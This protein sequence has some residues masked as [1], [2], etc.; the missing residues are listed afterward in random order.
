MNGRWLIGIDEAGYGPSM[1]PLVLGATSWW[2]PT[3]I[4][5]EE[6]AEL[7]APEIQ[8]KPPFPKEEHI[9]IGDSK[10]IMKGSYG[11][12]NLS[13]GAEWLIESSWMGSEPK[14]ASAWSLFPRLLPED[15]SRVEKIAWYRNLFDEA[16]RLELPYLN[17]LEDSK[18]GAFSPERRLEL[19]KR[20]QKP[21]QEKLSALGIRMG[22]SR[23][24]LID[25]PE[26][27]RQVERLGNKS[28]LL[29]TF[30]LALAKSVAID[31]VNDL[32]V[33]A[34]GE[35]TE[36]EIY[37]DKHGG[38]SRYQGLLMS[39]FDGCWMEVEEEK[40]ERSRY[41]SDW[42]GHPVAFQF[43]AKGDSLVP[44]A[45]ASI[46]A[47]WLREITM[48]S[49]NQF[50]ASHANTPLRPTAGYYV[51]ALRF[52]QEIAPITEK[53]QIPRSLWWRVK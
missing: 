22:T 3:H 24:R 16:C 18:E 53:L 28:T 25:E 37:F 12:R 43:M 40:L 39:C 29:S 17:Y 34:Q 1:G 35:P 23:A 33:S 41:R 30:S 52:S 51:D 20:L 14:E 7:L 2:V 50:W 48:A 9:P 5:V 15:A 19:R 27:N 31:C 47:K 10:K 46:L 44:S 11:W 49:L 32:S 45:A 4:S 26:F 21:I 13:F 6:L 38:R 42:N 8:P 36:I